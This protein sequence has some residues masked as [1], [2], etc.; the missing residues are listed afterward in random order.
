MNRSFGARLR[1]ERE[2]RGVSLSEISQQTKIK[3]SLLESLERGDFSYWPRGLF[4]RAY[5]RA[6]ATAIH[7][8]PDPVLREFVELHPDPPDE[9]A[10]AE[11]SSISPLSTTGRLWKAVASAMGAGPAGPAHREQIPDTPAQ[12]I[13]AGPPLQPSDVPRFTAVARLCMQVQQAEC[14][15]E[16]V[17]VLGNI[18]QLLEATGVVLWSWDSSVAGLQPWL[19]HGYSPQVVDN[20]PLVKRDEDNAIASAFRSQSP[21]IVAGGDMQTGAIVVPVV[22]ANRCLGALSLELSDGR[23]Q[24]IY[25]RDAAAI[26]AALLARFVEDVPLAA[27]VNG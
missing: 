9:F 12:R 14:A 3:S 18:A 22:A 16:L 6:Y 7:V 5:I 11:T 19:T 13:E 8:D 15:T 1:L 4:G 20:L 24:R 17:P 25:V 21:R 2:Q 23:E 10:N 27:V 26:F